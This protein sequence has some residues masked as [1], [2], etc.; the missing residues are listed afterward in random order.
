MLVIGNGESRKDV[1]IDDLPI[2][3]VGC[4]AIIR[5]FTVHHLICCDKKMVVEALDN[6]RISNQNIYTRSDW[7][8]LF[9][10]V[11][12]VPELW[13][14]S[15]Q[16]I[17]QPWHWG[18]GDY[19]VLLAS[20][21]SKSKQIHLLGFDLFGTEGKVNNLYKDTKNY[22]K[23]DSHQVDPS[24]WIYHLAKI[25]EHFPDKEYIVYSNYGE[26]TPESWKCLQ[27]VRLDSLDNL[28]L[29]VE[30]NH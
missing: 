30:N 3:K 4:N 2:E 8:N 26:N 17:D 6:K 20:E 28:K 19:A 14:E 11:K 25:F 21:I 13:Y 18:S 29:N 7:K 24:Y 10:G 22:V 16:R 1:N 12:N 15:D 27:N 23:A 9:P 5:D